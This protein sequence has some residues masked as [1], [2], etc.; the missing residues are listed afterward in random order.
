ML[1]EGF[2]QQ[3]DPGARGTSIQPEAQFRAGHQPA[4]ASAEP[5]DKRPGL[6]QPQEPRKLLVAHLHRN[7]MQLAPG[8]HRLQVLPLARDHGACRPVPALLP[9]GEA[10]QLPHHRACL[11]DRIVLR[12]ENLHPPPGDGIQR[13]PSPS[14]RVLP[15]SPVDS[16]GMPGLHS[17]PCRLDQRIRRRDDVSGGTVVR[18]QE[19][20]LRPVVRFES[21]DELHRGA[22]ERIDVLVVVAHREDRELAIPVLQGPAGQ[23]RDQ[24]VLVRVDVLVLVHQDPAKAREEPLALLVRFLRDQTLPAQ[25]G[26]RLLHHLAERLAVG[27]VPPSR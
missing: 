11:V 21:P 12:R 27:G 24:L 15:P 2:A 3:L 22:V 23:R 13:T 4:L 5:F 1:V 26:H 20:G 17:V 6:P 18:G 19:G 9:I 16:N 10:Q 14:R 25:Q 8:A 7:A